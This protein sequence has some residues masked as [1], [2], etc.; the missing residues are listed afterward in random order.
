MDI[1]FK[2]HQLKTLANNASKADKKLG[3]K[4][5]NL[6]RRR[7]NELKNAQC[8]EDV[9][10]LP[11]AKYHQLKGNRSGTFACNLDHP[12][13]LVF[14]PVDLDDPNHIDW[15]AIEVVSIEEIVNY[16]G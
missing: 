5:A 9:R 14:K 7:L 4:R 6:F 10:N 16:H 13:R 2:N 3:A 15:S 12:Y 8:L 11:G 1:F